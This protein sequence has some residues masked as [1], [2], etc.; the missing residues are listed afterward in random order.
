MVSPE[1]NSIK[2]IRNKD[3]YFVI[4]PLKEEVIIETYKKGFWYEFDIYLAKKCANLSE[5]YKQLDLLLANP[6]SEITGYSVYEVGGG[7]R[8]EIELKTASKKDW[9]TLKELEKNFWDNDFKDVIRPLIEK[10][11]KKFA[12]FDESSIV[13]RVIINSK[14][15]IPRLDNDMSPLTKEIKQ[16]F[17]KITEKEKNIFFTL[18]SLDQVGNIKKIEIK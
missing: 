11:N 8:G 7:W 5:L 9:K 3:K 1:K 10:G 13:L 15:R 16:I 18:K 6:N 4:K 2:N 12:V 14:T 17:E